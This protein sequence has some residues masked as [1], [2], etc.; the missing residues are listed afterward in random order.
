MSRPLR[1]EI[2]GG[3]YHVTSR[4]D[5]REEI[6][7]VDADRVLWLDVLAQCCERFNWAVHAWCQMGNHYHVV[8]ETIEGNL[9]SGMRHL[10]GV[11]TQSINR[12]YQRAG[13]V[14]QGR[15]K[16]IVVNRESHLLE[17]LRH[18][19]LNPVRAGM[20]VHPGQWPWSSYRA[21][22]GQA[23][24]PA[25]FNRQWTLGQFATQKARQIAKYEEFVIQGIGEDTIWAD[26]KGQIFLG[27]DEFAQTM[28]QTLAH[29]GKASSSEIPRAQRRAKAMS[30]GFY[31]DTFEDDAKQGMLAAYATGDY[32][33]QAVADAFGV[34]YS[35]VSRAVGGK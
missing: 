24:C 8:V 15:Y 5:R 30:L 31:T 6:Y 4:G 13:H 9:S 29:Q 27:S 33:L 1:I 20:A 3:V 11:F 34:H 14:F 35:T 21:M 28:Q 16:A 17:L 7:H 12:R 10:N 32:T 23:E 26:L 22:V 19:V 18:V 2:P 25:W